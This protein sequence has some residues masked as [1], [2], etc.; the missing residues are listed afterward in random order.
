MT[1]ELIDWIDDNDMDDLLSKGHADSFVP[2]LI[3]HDASFDTPQQAVRAIGGID[4]GHWRFKR[5]G[6]DILTCTGRTRP[7][8]RMERICVNHR[9]G[10]PFVNAKIFEEDGCNHLFVSTNIW[11]SI[12]TKIKNRKKN[13][14]RKPTK[15]Y[16]E[17]IVK[18]FDRIVVP[19]VSKI[20]VY[21][22]GF[23]ASG[24]GPI[25]VTVVSRRDL[26][27][28]LTQSED[29]NSEDRLDSGGGDWDL[30]GSCWNVKA[31]KRLC[32]WEDHVGTWDHRLETCGINEEDMDA[33]LDDEP[34]EEA[35]KIMKQFGQRIK[36]IDI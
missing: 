29:T 9:I 21:K 23:E 33:V 8:G 17:H 6:A 15:D 16:T 31:S 32:I 30:L 4:W 24:N 13:R 5:Q 10:V 1:E 22:W 14:S 19:E 3:G 7:D 2:D 35:K 12:R 28:Y 27:S 11:S 20:S 26:Y 36:K 25:S 34:T 18:S